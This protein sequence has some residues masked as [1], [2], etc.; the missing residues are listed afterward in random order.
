M[1]VSAKA[2]PV[3]VVPKVRT[4]DDPNSASA[5]GSPHPPLPVRVTSTTSPVAPGARGTQ[6]S[7]IPVRN[8]AVVGTAQSRRAAEMVVKRTGSGKMEVVLTQ[9]LVGE[10]T[11]RSRLPR[12]L[13]YTNESVGSEGSERSEGSEGSEGSVRSVSTDRTQVS[14]SVCSTNSSNASHWQNPK[15]RRRELPLKSCLKTGG[16]ADRSAKEAPA[17]AVSWVDSEPQ[18]VEMP[19]WDRK[20]PQC[21]HIGTSAGDVLGCVEW[22]CG[23]GNSAR[24]HPSRIAPHHSFRRWLG[25][26][27]S[28]GHNYV[29]GRELFGWYEMVDGAWWPTNLHRAHWSRVGPSEETRRLLEEAKLTAEQEARNRE[30]DSVTF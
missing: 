23:F 15:S 12:K 25:L 29:A 19:W 26:Q 3:A 10:A 6:P 7:R 13:A 4:V 27:K 2:V 8:R 21:K 14:T 9:L 16:P 11:T 17:K 20:N 5:A 30:L 24:E 28:L 1:K 18:V 22:T